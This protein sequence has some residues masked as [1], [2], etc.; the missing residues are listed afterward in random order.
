MVVVPEC[1]R[2]KK[3][4]VEG[5]ICDN[6]RA[7]SVNSSD[8]HLLRPNTPSETQRAAAAAPLLLPPA[9]TGS[10]RNALDATFTAAVFCSELVGEGREGAGN[11][12]DHGSDANRHE[13]RSFG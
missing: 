1:K 3:L 9:T 13:D 5:G 8:T 4:L 11:R 7:R 10:G 2:G 6:N 12:S